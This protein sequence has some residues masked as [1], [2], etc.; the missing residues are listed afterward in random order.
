MQHLYI[1]RNVFLQA[2][3]KNTGKPAIK[4]NQKWLY[5]SFAGLMAV[6]LK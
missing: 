2:D 3:K 5:T 6:W 1:L 4:D